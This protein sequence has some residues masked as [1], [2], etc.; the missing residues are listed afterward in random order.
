MSTDLKEAW[1]LAKQREAEWREERLRIEAEMVKGFPADHEGTEDIGGIKINFKHTKRVDKDALLAEAEAARIPGD[2][3]GEL[4][5]WKPEIDAKAWKSASE[6]EKTVL[7]RA[8]EIK[9]AK[10]SFSVSK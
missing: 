3:L 7:G 9:P 5:R 8:I 1:K 4:F 2:R 6:F 10:P